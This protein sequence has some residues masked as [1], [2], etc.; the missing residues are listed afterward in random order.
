MCVKHTVLLTT[1]VMI[2]TVFEMLIL[3]SPSVFVRIINP[4]ILFM[5]EVAR[6]LS[7]I[8]I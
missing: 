1:N 6:A 7:N 2:L 4:G 3:C 5:Y 8:I